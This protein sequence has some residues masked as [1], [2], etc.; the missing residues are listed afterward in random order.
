MR[1]ADNTLTRLQSFYRVPNSEELICG[2]SG[3]VTTISAVVGLWCMV[4]VSR[5]SGCRA[6]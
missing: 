6:V 4:E 3:N 2:G 1:K 5:V